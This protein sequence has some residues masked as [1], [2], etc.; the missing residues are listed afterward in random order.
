MGAEDCQLEH[1]LSWWSSLS[2]KKLGFHSAERYI[3][4]VS[5][6]GWGGPE[7]AP[8]ETWSSPGLRLQEVP[9]PDTALRRQ[10]RKQLY[11]M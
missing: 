10:E 1:S 3:L 7:E 9:E 8:T 11:E 4:F 6:K 5:Q 2:L